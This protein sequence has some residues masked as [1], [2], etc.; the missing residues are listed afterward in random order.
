MDLAE[1][2]GDNQEILDR[3]QKIMGPMNGPWRESIVL[4]QLVDVTQAAGV[5]G[6]RIRIDLSICRGLD[7]YTGTIFETFLTDLP[8][9]G[10]ICSGGRYDNLAG[11]YTKQSLPGVGASLGL[12]RLLAALEKLNLLKSVS[13]P[14]PVL[15]VQFSADRLG[16]YQRMARALREAGIGVEVFP[17]AKKVGAQLQFAEKRG[18]T[19]ALIAGPDEFAQGVWKVKDLQRREEKTIANDE[20]LAAIQGI[21]HS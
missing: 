20:V 5:A 11:K 16:D 15:L 4:R 12:D 17:E 3:L 2:V 1:T 18:F 14:A 10:S 21:L 6:D 9:I 8:T 13:T 7:Y 19:L